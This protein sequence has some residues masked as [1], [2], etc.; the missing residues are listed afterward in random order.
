MAEEAVPPYAPTPIFTE[1]RVQRV[2]PSSPTSTTSA[3]LADWAGLAAVST[4]S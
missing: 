3:V 1:V 4:D 2:P